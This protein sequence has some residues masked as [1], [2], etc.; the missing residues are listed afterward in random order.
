MTDELENIKNLKKNDFPPDPNKSEEFEAFLS[1]IG[2]DNIENW[3]IMAEALDVRPETI[4][5]W[6]KHPK[7][8]KAIHEAIQK[9]I[10]GMNRSGSMDWRM[11]R[12]KLKML[13]II[14]K[15]RNELTGKDGEA[16]EYK[17]TDEQLESIINAKI[18]KAGTS[19]LT[20]GEGTQDQS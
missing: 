13:G 12:E 7:A 18:G 15:Q 2:N 16:I 6:K 9:S 10:Q 14:E 8:R 3:T 1:L 19:E 11:H 17:Y 20:S 4:T 5:R